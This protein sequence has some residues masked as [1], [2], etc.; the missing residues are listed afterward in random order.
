MASWL[1]KNVKDGSLMKG[2]KDGSRRLKDEI[3]RSIGAGSEG[4]LDPV[5]EYRTQRFNRYNDRLEELSKAMT[6]YTN[7]THAYAQATA[8]LMHA[9]SAFFESQM[10]DAQEVESGDQT[11]GVKALAQSSLRV[12]EIQ[13]SLQQNVFDV[14]QSLQY[15]TVVQPLQE[16]RGSNAGLSQQLRNLKQKLNDFDSAQRSAEAQ[17]RSPPDFE[18][19][20]Q[21]LQAATASLSAVAES[22]D[23]DMSVIE[24]RRDSALKNELLTVVASQIFIHSRANEHLQ[25]LVPL[26]PGVA[27][28]LILLLAESARRRQP[29]NPA[30]SDVMGVISYSG[31]Y[32]RG[33]LDQPLRSH[34]EALVDVAAVHPIAMAPFKEMHIAEKMAVSTYGRRQQ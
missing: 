33:T 31:E 24:A 11:P 1:M 7:A 15:R 20:Q 2:V 23:A 5:L 22:V 6:H 18:K 9:F 28:P 17:K 14:A 30:T 16:L 12:E 34:R 8:Q 21:K 25:Q 26:L 10:Q 19:A 3:A 27:K 4:G 32:S 29:I 13:Q